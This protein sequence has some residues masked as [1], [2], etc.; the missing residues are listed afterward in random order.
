MNDSLVQ[1]VLR[2]IPTTPM[3]DLGPAV[4]ARLQSTNA[5]ARPAPKRAFA[6]AEWFW[7]PRSFALQWRPAYAF[8]L[9]A[10]VGAF[11]LLSRA[12]T[13][14]APTQTILVQFRLDAPHANQVQLAGNFTNWKPIHRLQRSGTGVWTVVVAVTP[15][16]HSYG[17][18]VD[19]KSWVV[20]P[21]ARSVAD[22]F[23]GINSQLALLSPETSKSL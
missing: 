10:F 11:A 19:G 14:T 1:A 18:V 2:S 4:L 6:L 7:A 8:A 23:G 15:G 5:P 22:G 20:D 16:V 9:I 13:G 17:F 3:P 12:G 21:A